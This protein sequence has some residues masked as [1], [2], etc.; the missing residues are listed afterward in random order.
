M[1]HFLQN[2]LTASLHGSVVVLVV[3]LLRAIL[4]KT[5]KKFI[6]LLW[7][8][9]GVRLL[10]PFEVHSDLSLQPVFENVSQVHFQQ[11]ITNAP[12]VQTEFATIETPHG[13]QISEDTITIPTL[14]VAEVVNESHLNW[15][16][17]VFFIWLCIACLFFLYTT[18]AYVKLKQLVREAVKIRGGWECDR[19]DTAFILGFIRPQ[20]YIPMGL[21][22]EVRKH[23]LAHERTHLE[24]GDHWFKM[25][26]FIALALHWFNPLVWVAYIMLCKDIE[27]ACDERVV[28]FMELPERNTALLSCSTNR[29]HLAACPVAFGEVSV[30]YR[31]RSVL[32]YKKP[33]FWISLAGVI[34]IVFVAVCLVTSPAEET[35]VFPTIQETAEVTATIEVAEIQSTFASMLSEEDIPDAISSGIQELCSRESYRATA[36]YKTV[37]PTR[38]NSYFSYTAEIY[39]YGNDALIWQQGDNG[40]PMN[41]EVFYG[42]LYGR[43]YGDYWVSQGHRTV[44]S[45][46]NNWVKEYSPEDKNITVVH[47]ENESTISYNATWEDSWYTYI[48]TTWITFYDD[49][50]IASIQRKYQQEPAAVGNDTPYFETSITILEDLNPQATYKA[51]ADQAVQCLTEEELETV[52]KNQETMAVI[53]SNKTDYDQDVTS[54][55]ISRQWRFLDNAWNVRIGSDDVK[56]TGLRQTFEESGDG[57]SFFTVEEGFWLETFDGNKWKLIKE[58]LELSPAES[59]SISVAWNQ[60]DSFSIDWS[61]SYGEL[62]EGYYRLGRYYTVTMED[63]RT[64][65]EPCYCKFQIR[66]QDVDDLLKECKVGITQLENTTNYY[67]KIRNYLRND[68]FRG[69][70]DANSHDLT[71]EIWRSGNNYYTEI[72]YCYKADGSIKSILGTLFRDGKG[73]EINNGKVT[74]VDW[75]TSDSFE[76]WS[77]SAQSFSATNLVSVYKDQV[78]TIYVKESS[79][80]YD[81]IPFIEQQY[82]FTEDGRLVGYRRI[83]LNEA[84]EEIIDFEMERFRTDEGETQQKINSISVQ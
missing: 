77:K 4:R 64:E 27:M 25:I 70:I 24:K 58:P 1:E 83:F 20:I 56:S 66:N 8:L 74:R 81:G 39:R 15:I 11:E 50:T 46:V 53:P 59:K 49:G 34:A 60:R 33:S 35:G 29:V 7:L 26:G 38:D 14:D 40:T 43:H 57:H 47:I 54:G 2:L 79:S 5:P 80:F 36:L 6:C 44:D 37:Y 17:I 10:M 30:K 3:I 48:G 32:R 12:E 63:G 28:Q 68:E 61:N 78:G 9:A 16:A 67:L 31:I 41:S 45:D 19:I 62:P 23:I 75:V 52:R 73:Y 21:S 71:Q 72:T 13:M 55:I 84:G 51:I 22:K 18:M 76:L 82:S 42:D 69:K 65:T